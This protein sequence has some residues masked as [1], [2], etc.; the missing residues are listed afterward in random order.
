MTNIQ[1]LIELCNLSHLYLGH[2]LSL[3]F[4]SLT[5]ELI[6]LDFTCSYFLKIFRFFISLRLIYSVNFI[7]L[8][9]RN[10]DLN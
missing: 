5:S 9:D 1:Y 2:L 3:P 8:Y 10:L 6:P 4:S 7:I